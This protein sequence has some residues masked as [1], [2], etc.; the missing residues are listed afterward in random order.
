MRL[1]ALAC[2]L[3]ARGDIVAIVEPDQF[4]AGVDQLVVGDR[5]IDDRGGDLGADLHRAGVDK[6]VVGRLIVSGMEPPEEQQK[7]QEDAANGD[8]R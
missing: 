7:Q 6:G 8:K 1:S 5:N 3:I 4:G 2:G